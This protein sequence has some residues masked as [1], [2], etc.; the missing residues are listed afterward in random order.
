MHSTQPDADRGE[1]TLQDDTLRGRLPMVFARLHHLVRQAPRGTAEVVGVGAVLAWFAWLISDL[2]PLPQIGF[3]QDLGILLETGWRFTQGQL[4]HRDY[5]SPLGPAFSLIAGLPLVFGG[6][7]FEAYR[8]LPLALCTAFSLLAVV[9]THGRVPAVVAVVFSIVTGLVAGGTYHFGFSPDLLTFATLFNRVGWAGVMV[10]AAAWGLPARPQHDR[11]RR[12]ADG[13]IA[14]ALLAVLLFLKINF[15]L[16]SLG[17]LV[18]AVVLFSRLRER[19]GLVATALGFASVA[20]CFCAM[21]GWSLGG[22]AR[23]LG[24]A[25]QA[26]AETWLDSQYWNP[27]LIIL[28]NLGLLVWWSVV[29]A[30]AMRERAWRETMFSAFMLLAGLTL[31]GSNS[32]GTGFGVPLIVSAVLTLSVCTRGAFEKTPASWAAGVFSWGALLATA[33]TAVIVPQIQSFIM[34]KHVATLDSQQAVQAFRGAPKPF[35]RLIVGPMGFAWR[36]DS[37]GVIRD[38]VESV[39]TFVPKDSTLLVIDFTNIVNFAA[40]AR[41]PRNTLLWID[42]HSTFARDEHVSPDHLH[43]DCD[44]VMVAKSSIGGPNGDECIR[45][46]LAIYRETLETTFAVEDDGPLFTIYKNRYR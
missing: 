15:F 26:R 19:T 37:V 16:V 40:S 30:V 31:A 11:G 7:H 13:L 44:Y 17:M 38:A 24:Y 42:H 8:H 46:W 27:G 12:I 33:M 41:S 9:V 10:L 39:R 6:H 1:A 35:D 28:N 2:P 25:A 14:G 32:S 43:R 5:V 4:P 34:W 36:D 20:L 21:I 23:D 18:V 29:A 3:G 45:A 22:M